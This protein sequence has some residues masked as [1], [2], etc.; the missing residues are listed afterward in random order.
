MLPNQAGLSRVHPA[1][2][3]SCSCGEK[4]KDD[5]ASILR[6]EARRERDPVREYASRSTPSG[7]ITA[8]DPLETRSAIFESQLPLVTLSCLRSR[9]P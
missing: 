9:Q 3:V 1:T 7:L 8:A 2:L 6:R 4:N 5:L